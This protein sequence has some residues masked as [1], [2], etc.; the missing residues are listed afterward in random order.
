MCSHVWVHTYTHMNTCMH[1]HPHTPGSPPTCTHAHPHTHTFTCVCIPRKHTP[2]CRMLT[3]IFIYTHVHASPTHAL[4]TPPHA[5]MCTYISIH[6]HAYPCACIPPHTPSTLPTCRHVHLHT[7]THTRSFVGL[8]WTFSLTSGK[9]FQDEDGFQELSENG[10]SKDENIQ[11]KLPSKVVSNSFQNYKKNRT[12]FELS[13]VEG[14]L[15]IGGKDTGHMVWGLYV[16]VYSQHLESLPQLYLSL[17]ACVGGWEHGMLEEDR[18]QL[19]AVGSLWPWMSRGTQ[20]FSLGSRLLYPPSLT[21]SS[22]K[23]K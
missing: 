11:Q 10:N 19:A 23:Q 17:C 22:P 5:D 9:L 3:Y 13:Y 18:G 14:S 15:E 7:H 8:V 16:S 2:T 4:S 12:A 6:T 1:P 20:V 21:V